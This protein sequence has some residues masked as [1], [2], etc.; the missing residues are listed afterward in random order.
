M[1]DAHGQTPVQSGMAEHKNER[2]EMRVKAADKS[3]WA[4]AAALRG[5]TLTEWLTS[6]GNRNA[7]RQVGVAERAAEGGDE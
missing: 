6:I 4:R 3:L 5:E 1:L 2:M 7:R